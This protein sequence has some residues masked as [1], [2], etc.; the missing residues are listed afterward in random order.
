VEPARRTFLWGISSG[1]D[2]PLEA[3]RGRRGLH[4]AS[5]KAN[6]LT[7]DKGGRLLRGGWASRSVCGSERDGSVTTLA[8]HTGKAHQQP[9]DIVVRSDGAIY[10]TIHPRALQRRHASET[11]SSTRLPGRVPHSLTREARRRDH[12]YVYPNGLAFTPDESV[13][14]VNDTRLG[15]IRAYDMRPDGSCGP[16]RLF[17]K[18]AAASRHRRR[19]EVDREGNVYCTGPAHSRNR[20]ME[21]SSGESASRTTAPTWPGAARLALALHHD[22]NSVFRTRVNERASRSG[23]RRE[24]MS[25]S[26]AHTTRLPYRSRM[27]RPPVFG[28]KTTMRALGPMNGSPAGGAHR[29]RLGGG[30]AIRAAA[31]LR[32]NCLPVAA[33]APFAQGADVLWRVTLQL[34]FAAANPRWRDRDFCARLARE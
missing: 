30:H 3:G 28:R 5:T 31:G 18:L 2:P 26:R 22:Y 33:G 9:N 27:F 11:C 25:K 29:R 10:F 32:I 20:P 13:L 19:H 8:S 16:K 6:G 24:L 1:H 15:E 17:H 21:S 23:R 12:R 4:P 7:F 34:S 14:Y